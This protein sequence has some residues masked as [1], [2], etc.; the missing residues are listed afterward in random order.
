[1]TEHENWV[2]FWCIETVIKHRKSYTIKT[3]IDEAREVANFVLDT[4]PAQV[5]DLIKNEIKID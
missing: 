3:A 5:F 1:M 2:R 4:K